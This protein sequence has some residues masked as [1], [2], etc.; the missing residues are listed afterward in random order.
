MDRTN[1][2]RQRRYIRRLKDRAAAA[3]T[4]GPELERLRQENAELRRALAE[5]KRAVSNA[6]PKR[7]PLPPDELRDQQIA[8]LKKRKAELAAELQRAQVALRHRMPPETKRAI[9]RC[10]HPNHAP[11]PEE[12]NSAQVA[13]NIWLSKERA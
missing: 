2:E 3:V 1:A 8:R 4:N 5:A 7:A 6:K 12:R 11:S 9:I 13:F 10:L